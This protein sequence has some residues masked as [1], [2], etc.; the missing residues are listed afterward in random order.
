ME[1]EKRKGRP[2]IYDTPEEA[3]K[4]RNAS[5]RDWDRQHLVRFTVACRKE[6]AEQIQK[7]ADME[8]TNRNRF[9]VEAATDRAN[10]IL[11]EPDLPLN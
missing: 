6:V 7:A 5:N 8:G 9:I 1:E 2:R 10:E 11:N 3:K 4:A